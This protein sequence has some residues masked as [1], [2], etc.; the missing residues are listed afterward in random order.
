[1]LGLA[2]DARIERGGDISLS[3]CAAPASRQVVLAWRRT[4]LRAKEFQMLASVL[5]RPGGV[6]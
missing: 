4:S 2:C 1:V 5:R 6:G 3:R